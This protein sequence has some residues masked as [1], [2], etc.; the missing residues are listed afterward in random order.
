MRPNNHKLEAA[1]SPLQPSSRDLIRVSEAVRKD[2]SNVF[3]DILDTIEDND[4]LD[5]L[6]D[7]ALRKK[8]SCGSVLA[9]SDLEKS[10]KNSSDSVDKPIGTIMVAVEKQ[11]VARKE[12]KR[13]LRPWMKTSRKMPRLLE[14]RMEK[15]KMRGHPSSCNYTRHIVCRVASG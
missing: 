8:M 6:V 12:E 14:E 7:Q 10:H 2:E 11:K 5:E 15:L 4:W 13:L 9:A 1:S 3:G